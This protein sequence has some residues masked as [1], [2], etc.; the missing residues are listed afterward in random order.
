LLSQAASSDEQGAVLGTGQSL[1][2]LARILGPYLGIQLLGVSVA[3]PYYLAA[4][5]MVLGGIQIAR[6]GSAQPVSESGQ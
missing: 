5:L 6:M 1:S 4:G 3:T 2:S